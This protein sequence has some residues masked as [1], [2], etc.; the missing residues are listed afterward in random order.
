MVF[1]FLS[2]DGA[3]LATRLHGGV[4]ARC[5]NSVAATCLQ[6]SNCGH[7]NEAWS[8]RFFGFFSLTMEI[9]I[10]RGLNEGS[11]RY[12]KGCFCFCC[13][14][15]NLHTKTD[16]VQE[17]RDETTAKNISQPIRSQCQPNRAQYCV[18][19]GLRFV[20][21]LVVRRR[22]ARALAEYDSQ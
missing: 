3:S 15:H 6:I 1:F 11:R 5:G 2:Q 7:V 16:W 8:P 12:S 21:I 9:Q 14:R 22:R 18:L 13:W 4:I 20:A 17:T 10:Q 19:I